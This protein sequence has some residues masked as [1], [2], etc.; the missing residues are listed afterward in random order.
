M[1][2]ILYVPSQ[3]D[4]YGQYYDYGAIANIKGFIILWPIISYFIYLLLW[5]WDYS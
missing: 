3:G 5:Q 1:L 4:F 2:L